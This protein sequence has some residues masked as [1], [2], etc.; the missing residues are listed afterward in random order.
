MRQGTQPREL[1]KDQIFE[2]GGQMTFYPNNISLPH[3]TSDTV[4]AALC[5][6]LLGDAESK[7]DVEKIQASLP[8][9]ARKEWD[10]AIKRKK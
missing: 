1:E 3:G 5:L 8:E 2:P 6:A 10:E 4:A 9:A 7:A